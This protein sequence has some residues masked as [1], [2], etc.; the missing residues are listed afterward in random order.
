VHTY[1]EELK[2]KNWGKVQDTL[3]MVVPLYC[4]LV[5]VLSFLVYMKKAK[6]LKK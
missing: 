6:K 2:V 5:I 1:D 4:V 3:S